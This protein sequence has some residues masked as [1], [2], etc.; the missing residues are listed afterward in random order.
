MASTGVRTS[1]HTRTCTAACAARGSRPRALSSAAVIN[2]MLRP[3]SVYSIQ[4][5]LRESAM[6]YRL[7]PGNDR[8]IVRVNDDST[9]DPFA[10]VFDPTAGQFVVDALNAAV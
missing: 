6:H 10:V 7:E 4:K 1:P 5:P 8:R 2:K 9:E 3:S